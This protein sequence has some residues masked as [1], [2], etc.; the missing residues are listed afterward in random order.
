MVFGYSAPVCASAGNANAIRIAQALAQAIAI[1]RNALTVESVFAP[2]GILAT[3]ASPTAMNR[4]SC[5]PR[6]TGAADCAA[7]DIAWLGLMFVMR[8]LAFR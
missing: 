6:S 2:P 1:A 4:P 5:G 8:L 3:V 7:R